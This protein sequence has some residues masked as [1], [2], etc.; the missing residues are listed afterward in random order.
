MSQYTIIV[1]NDESQWDDRTGVSYHFPRKYRSLLTTGTSVIYYKGSQ[2]KSRF[3]KQ[4]MSRDPHYFGL[5]KI[6]VVTQDTLNSAHYYAEI[7]DYIPFTTA[8]HIRNNLGNYYEVP[9]KDNFWRDG[10]RASSKDVFANIL[11]QTNLVFAQNCPDIEIELGNS[12]YPPV[13]DSSPVLADDIL[14]IKREFER[15]KMDK[16]GNSGGFTSNS[17]VIGDRAEEIVLKYLSDTLLQ[18]EKVTLRWLAKDGETPGYDVS[19]VN[20]QDETICI[21]VKGTTSKAFLSFNITI[22][23]WMAAE[24]ER[25]N[26]FIYLVAECFSAFPSIQVIKNPFELCKDWSLKPLA[27]RVTLI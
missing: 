25:D 6:G 8:V 18:E 24:R 15:Q 2:R 5:A 23:E 20:Q 22:N 27:Y 9:T 13:N 16:G 3:S 19:Y 7:T 11:N 26:Y 21:E 10:V 12:Q 1:E 4:R 17:K 14:F